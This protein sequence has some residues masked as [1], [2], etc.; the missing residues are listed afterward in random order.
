MHMNELAAEFTI[1]TLHIRRAASTVKPVNGDRSLSVAR[2]SFISPVLDELGI[3]FWIRLKLFDVRSFQ[4]QQRNQQG[5][6]PSD[7]VG[8][9]AKPILKIAG[10]KCY[11]I[12]R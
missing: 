4:R 3:S 5:C 1:N 2:T 9:R 10:V 6:K 11:K 7:P 8:C 12:P